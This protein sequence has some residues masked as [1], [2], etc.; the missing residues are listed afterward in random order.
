MLD[1]LTLILVGV[2]APVVG[3]GL[4]LLLPR[5]M[6]TLRT[7]ASIGSMVASA[8]ALLTLAITL[9]EASLADATPVGVPFAP[10]LDI[11]LSFL[12]DQLGLF[13]ALLVAVVGVFITIYARGYFGRAPDD[14]YR[15]F[16]TLGLFATA[17]LGLVLADDF[18]AM[19]VFWELTSVSSFLLIGWHREDK[20]AVLLAIQAL[21]VTGVG[22]MLLMA[23]L[24]GL[25]LSTGAWSFSALQATDMHGA[26]EGLLLAAFLLIFAGAGAK[27]AQWPVH[28]WLPGAM[29]A[30]TP[31][32][33]Y[34]HSA[35]M[36]KAGVYL[37]GRLFPALRDLDWWTPTLVSFGATTMLLG[38]YV[39]LRSTELKRIF[40][41]TTVSQ[42]GLLT[43]MYGLGGLAD[44]GHHGEH[45][46]HSADHL[47]EGAPLASAAADPNVIWPVM[48]ILNHAA[49]KAPLFIVAGAIIHTLHRKH[50]PELRGLW[51][52]NRAFALTLLL[53]AYALAG[54]PLTLSF[55]AKEAFLY[56]I[57]HAAEEHPWFWAVGAMAV[58]TAVCNVA[59]FTRIARTLVAPTEHAAPPDATRDPGEGPDDQRLKGAELHADPLARREIEARER[60]GRARPAGHQHPLHDEAHERGL[61][62]AGIWWPALAIV[63]LQYVCGVY[64]PAYDALF[65]AVETH[66][67]YWDH[68]PGFVYAL[69]HPSLAL[70][71]SAVAIALGF[72]L[73]FSDLL[74]RPIEDVHARLFPAAYG[75][76]QKIGY[77]VFRTLQ[78]GNLRTYLFFVLFA[79]LVG[80]GAVVV[81][82]AETMLVWPEIGA[83]SIAPLELQL[84]SVFLTLLICG[85]ALAL[86]IVRTRVVRVLIL[87]VCGF[88]VTG[89]YIIYAAP[90]LALTQMM[91]E[92]ISV[93]LFMLALRLLPEEV[94]FNRRD[95]VGLRIVFSTAVG[96]AIAFLV[97]H[98]GAVADQSAIAAYERQ[99]TEAHHVAPAADASRV[100]SG[101]EG[102]VAAAVGES[103]VASGASAVVENGHGDKRH[104]RAPILGVD[105]SR[106]GGWFLQN[107]YSGETPGTDGR[108]GGGNNVVNVILVDFRGYDTI[109][110]ITVLSITMMGV[111]ALLGA[112]PKPRRT[113]DPT[114]TLTL[115]S[116]PHLRSSMLGTV[117][118]LILPLVLLFAGYVFFKGH[119]EA[120][121]GFIAGLIASVGLAAYRMAAG[122]FALRVLLPI[123]PGIMAAFGLLIALATG[124][125]PVLLEAVTG[126]SG[127]GGLGGPLLMSDNQYLPLPGAGEFHWT[128][129]MLFDLGVF[130]VVVA[131]SV[132]MINRFEEELE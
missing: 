77:R 121:G 15:F 131:V 82:D 49:Y 81:A 9:P 22:G 64:P 73:G 71:M 35:T 126:G 40:A 101:D 57:V 86:P 102:D 80:L 54:L 36:V 2:F 8:A 117:M 59:I 109:G 103:G 42:L 39:A 87:G 85:S 31:V 52:T 79:F 60:N 50:L 38:A 11:N 74:K 115:G 27:S 34:L 25:G 7:L 29:A 61:W 13:F 92:I 97:L 113:D 10:S 63:S 124:L 104:A 68:L 88:S 46:S 116:Q 41:Y 69:T 125:T 111:L 108:G 90:D 4:T 18:L 129:V 105:D 122:N 84:A 83:F 91:F 100:V 107:T 65:G 106:L 123:K 37:F 53:G 21:V 23:G 72:A 30:P 24:L 47:G 75:G 127:A 33:A 67:L 70:A 48:Q 58:L 95:F 32:S 130:I 26:G 99:R 1:P 96:V 62:A 76:V 45:A 120:G 114:Q 119:N 110:E 16:P 128:S 55:A 6:V 56:Q 44:G 19:F 5:S 66:P 28:F 98:A 112:C 17:M 118:R 89:M 94:K 51:R 20:S 3:M 43:C 93:V 78:N 132:G 14:L 12:P